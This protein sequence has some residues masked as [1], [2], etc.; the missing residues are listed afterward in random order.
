M[1]VL[2]K[3]N[4]LMIVSL[5]FLVIARIKSQILYFF[6]QLLKFYFHEVTE[7]GILIMHSAHSNDT[8]IPKHLLQF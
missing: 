3:L 6:H 1:Q 8:E 2:V 7:T 4:D 5:V